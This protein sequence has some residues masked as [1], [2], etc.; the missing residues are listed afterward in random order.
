M[1]PTTRST[2]PSKTATTRY[3]GQPLLARTKLGALVGKKTPG[4]PALPKVSDAWSIINIDSD[5]SDS[6]LASTPTPTLKRGPPTGKKQSIVPARPLKKA[7]AL[8][9]QAEETQWPAEFHL[10]EGDT[11]DD[12]LNVTPDNLKV[13]PVAPGAPQKA[14]TLQAGTSKLS[15]PF[16]FKQDSLLAKG[17]NGQVGIR[18]GGRL[19]RKNSIFIDNMAEES[20]DGLSDIDLSAFDDED[21]LAFDNGFIS[22]N[23]DVFQTSSDT[24]HVEE[25]EEEVVVVKQKSPVKKMVA[26]PP[27]PVMLAGPSNSV[28]PLAKVSQEAAIKRL[29]LKQKLIQKQLAKEKAI[30]ERV[31]QAK[32]DGKKKAVEPI[33][34]ASS[35]QASPNESTD[36]IPW[37][38]SP[39][40][41]SQAPYISAESDTFPANDTPS[42]STNETPATNEAPTTNTTPNTSTA[43]NPHSSGAFSGPSEM[44]DQDAFAWTL[45]DGVTN[46]EDIPE[47]MRDTLKFQVPIQNVAMTNGEFKE[48][49]LSF[50]T[51]G[52]YG[53]VNMSAIIDMV[54]YGSD[55]HANIQSP[56]RI[57]DPTR[58]KSVKIGFRKDVESYGLFDPVTRT[59]PIF[60]VVVVA[61]K[62]F[63]LGSGQTFGTRAQRGLE[64][65][66]LQAELRRMLA[67]FGIFFEDMT[68][69]FWFSPEGALRFT[70]TAG[71]P[72]AQASTNR[73]GPNR[74][75]AAPAQNAVNALVNADITRTALKWTDRVPIWDSRR[76]FYH[77][78]TGIWRPNVLPAMIARQRGRHMPDPLW[79]GEIPRESLVNVLFTATKFLRGDKTWGLGFNIVGAQVMATRGGYVYK[80]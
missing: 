29:L 48:G 17:P 46:Y 57:S 10:M 8:P 35:P 50:Y 70:T 37:S 56:V 40:S 63:L 3:V 66:G 79:Q 65:F 21:F 38:P 28:K 26:K 45:S 30:L 53:T 80:G 16:A 24:V 76:H 61:E 25:E 19:E 54:S 62:S 23:D 1:A 47:I 11:E 7:K 31:R 22:D 60:R 32:R 73:A 20:G 59:I 67:M 58:I 44:S 33:I 4:T 12:F 77:Q 72:D 43:L 39:F 75:V 36:T 5:S 69:T 27:A 34:P 51:R 78:T 9:A 68:M 42:P 18:T 14:K 64:A 41:P 71:N 74:A 52:E 13:Q 49:D 6:G 2:K 55:D 15:S